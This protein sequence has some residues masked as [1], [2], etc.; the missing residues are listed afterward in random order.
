MQVFVLLFNARTA[1][2]GIHTIKY[3]ERNKILM[4]EEEEDAAHFALL[5][6]KQGFP[7]PT[8]ELIEREELEEFCQSVDYDIEFIPSYYD[9]QSG[10]ERQIHIP[11]SSS[12]E[13]FEW[14]ESVEE[15]DWKE[16]ES[17]T[18]DVTV[19][20]T[21]SPIIPVTESDIIH[22]FKNYVRRTVKK[23]KIFLTQVVLPKLCAIFREFSGRNK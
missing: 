14:K 10:C 9:P 12:V 8:V 4:F 5:L 22:I 16:N 6:E 1:N 23:I 13:E 18:A 17:I 21:H 11:P 15:F 19:T 2:E 3:E 7:T 20:S